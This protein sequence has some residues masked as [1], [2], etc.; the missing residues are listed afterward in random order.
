V[1]TAERL[2]LHYAN[3]SFE[4]VS[5]TVLDKVVPPSVA[6]PAPVGQVRGSWFELQSDAGKTVYRRH[7]AAPD[8][9]YTEIPTEEDPTKP[10]RA[11][12]VVPERTFSVLVPIKKDGNYLVLY[13]PAAGS[14]SRAQAAGEI[15]RIRLR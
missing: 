11:E 9:V 13:G 15:G 5:R 7:M 2:T 10:S 3:G 12:F 1:P 8:I 14:K 4:V 6:L